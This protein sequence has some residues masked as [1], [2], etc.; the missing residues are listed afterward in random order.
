ML[1]SVMK[2]DCPCCGGTGTKIDDENTGMTVRRTRLKANVRMTAL[3][4]ALRISVGFMGDLEHG[5]RRWTHARFT[6][7]IAAIKKL[8]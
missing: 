2:K 5:R 4:G 6:E 8:S 1:K 7:A 3:A